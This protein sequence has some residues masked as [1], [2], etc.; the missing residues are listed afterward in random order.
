MELSFR[1]YFLFTQLR[2]TSV[3]AHTAKLTNQYITKQSLVLLSRSLSTGLKFHEVFSLAAPR[4]SSVQKINNDGAE[5]IQINFLFYLPDECKTFLSLTF[6]SATRNGGR[7]GS[8]NPKLIP[9]FIH[10][11]SS[12]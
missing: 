5:K 8:V 1:V 7:S 3:Y 6:P 9:K 11:T 4:N 10:F 12:E 2:H